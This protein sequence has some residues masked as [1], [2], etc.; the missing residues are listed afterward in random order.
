MHQWDP[1]TP[2]EQTLRVLDDLVHSGKV[3]YLGC[4]NY[5]AYQTATALGLQRANGWAPFDVIQPMYKVTPKHP[6]RQRVFLSVLM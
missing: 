3:L 4:S 2:L 6:S 1:D 5:A